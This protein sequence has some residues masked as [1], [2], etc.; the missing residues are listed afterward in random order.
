MVRMTAARVDAARAAPSRDGA[1]ACS[2]VS[3]RL[4]APME[5][6]SSGVALAL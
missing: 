3:H 5:L 6:R 4:P 2:R 1:V